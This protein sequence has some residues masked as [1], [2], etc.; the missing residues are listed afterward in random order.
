MK[1]ENK[2]EA[3]LTQKEAAEYLKLSVSTLKRLRA[4]GIGAKYIKLKTGANGGKNTKI[5]YPIVELDKWL[6][7]QS[8]QT[9]GGEQ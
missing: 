6:D 9:A 3:V 7:S 2:T 8:I 4:N 5:L 1:N